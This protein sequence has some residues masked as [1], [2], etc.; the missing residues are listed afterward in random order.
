MDDKDRH[1]AFV[2]ALTTEHFVLQT[3]ASGTISEAAGRASLYVFFLSST[4]VAIGFTSRSREV[5]VPFIATVLPVLFAVGVFT[6]IRLVDTALEN[7]HFL[8]GIARIRGYYRTLTPEAA[9]YFAP[10]TGRWPE[11]PGPSLRLGMLF[12]LMS[13]SASM[14]ALIN[15]LVGGAG[16]TLLATELL[17]K[18]RKT[19]AVLIGIA[20]VALLMAAFLAYQ[21]WRFQT[22]E[23]AGSEKPPTEDAKRA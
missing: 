6:V 21:R 11:N 7:M 3:A 22:D 5:F 1:S 17:G 8:S 4:V 16:V 2:S 10:E 12:A 19:L 14:L 9:V 18:D 20:T 15:S 23:V 13:T